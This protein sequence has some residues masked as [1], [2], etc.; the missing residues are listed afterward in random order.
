MEQIITSIL[1][2][3][4]YK[5]SMLQAFHNQYPTATG[6]W[7]FKCRNTDVKLGFLKDQ[8]REQ[9]D[10]M[11]G[12]HLDLKDK[13]KLEAKAPFLSYEFLSWFNRDFRLNPDLVTVSEK[14]GDLVIIAEGFLVDINIFEVFI[15]SIV[16]ELYFEDQMEDLDYGTIEEV[17]MMRLDEKIEMLKE[18]PNLVFAEFGTRRRFSKEWQDKVVGRLAKE[19]P[20]AIGTS[21]V[22]L[23]LK[24]DLKA[25]GTVAHEFSMAHLGLVDRIDQAQSRALHVWRQEYGDQLGIALSDTFTTDAFLR[26]FDFSVARAYD[27]VRHDSG[28]AIEFGHK[29]INHYK[30]IGIDP[31]RKSIIFSD[32][33]TTEKAIKIWKEFA[34]LINISFGIGT[35]FSN[36][37]GLDTLNIVMKLLVCNDIPCVKISDEPGKAMGDPDMIEKVKRAYRVR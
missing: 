20:N 11:K 32:G 24:H 27:G 36:D 8:V 33:L 12:L 37:V 18:F 16:N 34:G 25:I 26:D 35:H 29:M 2:L 15:L 22:L 3:D 13:I 31:R 30:S 17:G 23:A 10:M 5:L 9:L 28:D 4:L 1:D 19:C 7:E 6:R 14:D 21:N